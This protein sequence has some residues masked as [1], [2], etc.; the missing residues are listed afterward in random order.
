MQLNDN[1]LR[2]RGPPTLRIQGQVCHRIGSLLPP[3]GEKPKF[4]QLYIYDTDNEVKNR[5]QNFRSNK[6]LDEQIV[7]KLKSMLDE[8]NVHAQFF[9]MA[10]DMLQ[11]NQVQDLKL[12]LIADRKTDGRIYNQP[13]VFEVAAFIVGDIHTVGFPDLFITFTCNPTWPE[14]TRELAKNNLKPQDRAD[15]VA[16]VFKMKFDL[17]MKDLTKKHVL[18][19]VLA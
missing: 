15:I 17:L 16:K 3:E 6:D 19:K 4:A 9:R 12:K 2:E 5:M 13:T 10:R 8:Y 14:I 18:G 11:T 1:N 7:N